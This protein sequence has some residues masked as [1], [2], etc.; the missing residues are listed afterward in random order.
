MR[1]L[2]RFAQSMSLGRKAAEREREKRGGGDLS[3]VLAPT[4]IPLATLAGPIATRTRTR[5]STGPAIPTSARKAHYRLQQPPLA[6]GFASLPTLNGA[7]D[8]ASAKSKSTRQAQ[9]LLLRR[10]SMKR[11]LAAH[12]A[13][14]ANKSQLPQGKRERA[15]CVLVSDRRRTTRWAPQIPPFHTPAWQPF[16]TLP[17]TRP[18]L[19]PLPSFPS[20]LPFPSHHHTH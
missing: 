3:F 5:R 14:G 2:L 20:T 6:F 19:V 1:M 7:S 13:D 8:N 15:Q 11:I 16:A 4:R 12:C 9:A 10:G 17:S 18:L